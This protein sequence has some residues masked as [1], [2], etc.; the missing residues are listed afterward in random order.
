MARE[1][2]T[3][4][5]RQTAVDLYESTPGATPKVIAGDLGGLPGCVD[6]VGRQA[7]LRAHDRHPDTAGGAR[8]ESRV[9]RLETEPAAALPGSPLTSTTASSTERVNHERVA[10]VTGEHQ[11]A[12]IRLRRRVRTTIPGQSGR[13]FPP[14]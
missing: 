13:G 4:E 11:L 8:P 7:G 2:D 5:S 6:A 9:V 14:T 10:R 3:D 12:G 1:N